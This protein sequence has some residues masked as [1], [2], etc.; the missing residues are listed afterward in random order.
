MCS[1]DRVRDPLALYCSKEQGQ[2]HKRSQQCSSATGLSNQHLCEECCLYSQYIRRV[3]IWWRVALCACFRAG[4]S[5]LINQDVAL[6]FK[7]ASLAVMH[8]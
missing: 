4:V 8:Q 1:L 2:P 6:V 5:N 7:V 3:Q